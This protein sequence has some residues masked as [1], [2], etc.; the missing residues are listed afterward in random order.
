M[1]PT[2][3][4]SLLHKDN[5]LLLSSAHSIYPPSG[6]P[7][8]SAF[9]PQGLLA[10]DPNISLTIEDSKYQVRRRSAVGAPVSSWYEPL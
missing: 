5:L 6:D 4:S 10:V 9:V 3:V 2:G 8:A 7:F 1:T